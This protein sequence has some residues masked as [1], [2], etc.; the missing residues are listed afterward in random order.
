ME[1]TKDLLPCK[2]QDGW[3]KMLSCSDRSKKQVKGSY[4]NDQICSRGSSRICPFMQKAHLPGSL[5]NR[6]S[7]RAC[8]GTIHAVRHILITTVL[9]CGL[10]RVVR[11]ELTL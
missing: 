8:A 1:T 6:K 10:F 11:K 4:R 2:L 9:I 3:S 5:R 7:A